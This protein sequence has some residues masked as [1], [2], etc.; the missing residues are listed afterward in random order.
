MNTRSYAASP[1]RV[2]DLGHKS[3]APVLELQERLAE[4]RKAG[5]I[6]DTLVLVEHDPVYTLGRNAKAGNILMSDEERRRLW[7]D[8]VKIG[9]GGDVTYHGPG[10]LVGY[11]IIH[12]KERGKGIVGYVDGLEQV[13]LRVLRD[14]GIEGGTDSKNR[15][16]WV[17]NDKIAAIGVRVTRYVTMHGFSINVSTDLKY[18]R[19]IVPCGIRDK[20]VT[21]LHLLKP[22]TGMEDVKKRIVEKFVEVFGY[23]AVEGGEYAIRNT[24]YPMLK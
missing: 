17:G 24:Q 3:Y 23:G 18:Y 13:I 1:L 20:G 21:S 10:Q 14:Y 2:L 12:L 9:R 22:G 19:G 7:V 8:V 4:E 15:G 5:R 16:V 6:P 11:P